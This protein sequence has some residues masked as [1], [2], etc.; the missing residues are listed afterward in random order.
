MQRRPLGLILG[1]GW[2][3]AGMGRMAGEI[4][5]GEGNRSEREKGVLSGEGDGGGGTAGSHGLRP[6]ERGSHRVSFD[7]DTKPF[8]IDHQIRAPTRSTRESNTPTTNT[9]PHS[10]CFV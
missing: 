5:K 1:A 2:A 4:E 3:S 8:Q 7:R 6:V 9:F 10:L